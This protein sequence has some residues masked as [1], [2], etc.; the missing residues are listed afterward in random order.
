MIEFVWCVFAYR[1][2]YRDTSSLAFIISLTDQRLLSY[3]YLELV[4]GTWGC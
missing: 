3:L 2:K 4:I 1:L